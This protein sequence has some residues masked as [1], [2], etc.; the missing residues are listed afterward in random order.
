MELSGIFRQQQTP[1]ARLAFLGAA[2]ALFASAHAGPPTLRFQVDQRGDLAVFGNT[3]G[4]DCRTAPRP[5]DPLVGSVDRNGCGGSVEDSSPD[6]LW[7]SDALASG[8]ATASQ[9]VDPSSASTTAMLQLPA[10]STVT[11]ARIYWSASLNE[12]F[13]PSRQVVIDRP[14]PNGFA[15]ITVMADLK[16]LAKPMGGIAAFQASADI[17]KIL[18]TYGAGVYRVRGYAT[19]PLLSLSQDVAWVAWSGVV[20]YRHDG[21]PIRNFAL[22]D[23]LLGVGPDQAVTQPIAGFAVPPGG[24]ADGKVAIVGYEGDSEK[25]GDSL[26]WNNTPLSD[27]QN[28]ADN[29]F[30]SSRSSLGQAVTLAGDL[31]QLAG[32]PGSMAGLDLDVMDISALLTPGATSATLGVAVTSDVVYLGVVATAIRSKKPILDTQLAYSPQSVAGPGTV[33]DFTATTKNTGDDTATG[34]VLLHKL[35]PGLSY[36]PGSVRVVSGPNSGSK[37]DA[38]ADDQADYD[39]NSRTLSIRLGNGANATTGGSIAPAD[40][41][42][43]VRYQLKVEDSALP[44]DIVTQTQTQSTPQSSPAAG[45]T[46]FPSGD[47]TLPGR[48]TVIALPKQAANLSINV[49]VS[50]DPAAV[51]Q[52]VVYAVS[53]GNKGPGIAPPGAVVTYSVPTGGSI[54]KVEPA[55]GWTCTTSARM[56]QC[57]GAVPVAANASVP[58]V[59]ITVR[60]TP[61]SDPN[62]PA[63]GQPGVG[64]GGAGIHVLVDVVSDGSTDPDRADNKLDLFTGVGRYREAG[65]GFSCAV[66]AQSSPAAASLTAAALALALLLLLRRRAA[67]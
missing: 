21:D 32:S 13:E 14:G 62:T 40:S 52:P 44:G 26:T 4:F 39:A 33:L 50:P 31:P 64:D 23:G 9:S 63:E 2:F 61:G 5:P 7:Q 29:F 54:E 58:A 57:S 46:L 18:Q 47:G 35:P 48:P 51:N 43:E 55:S 1:L 24:M 30:N 20:L 65:G 22:F 25:T 12:G 36:V 11:Y 27:A 28:P 67:R 3:G 8:T 10:G 42:I 19:S 53:V 60:P 37:T 59:R 6:V 56:V 38:P 66:G 41:P 34:V 16:D 45:P 17:T 49:A 15:P